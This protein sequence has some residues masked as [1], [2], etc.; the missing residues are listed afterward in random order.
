MWRN[1][2]SLPSFLVIAFT[3][4]INTHAQSSSPAG[5]RDAAPAEV[6]GRWALVATIRNAEDVTQFGVTQGGGV[7]VYDFKA[8]GTFAITRDESVV[9]T[10]TWVANASVVPKT[11]DHMPSV[12]GRPGPVVPGI[13]E[14]GG[15]VLKICFLPPSASNARPAK[16]EA[17]PENGSRIY[18]MK[19]DTK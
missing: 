4:A 9:E 6:V 11:L 13:Y 1:R 3:L 15:G 10:G 16:C 18:I 12:A 5:I 17:K 19:R 7:S 14:T 2:R 8:D